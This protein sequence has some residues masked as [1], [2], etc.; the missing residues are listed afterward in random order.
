V[1][2]LNSG[3][4]TITASYSGATGTDAIAVP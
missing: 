1:T 3:S 2:A 4:V